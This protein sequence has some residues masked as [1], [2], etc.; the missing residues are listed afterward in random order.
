MFL[1]KNYLFGDSDV[2]LDFT[3]GFLFFEF[4]KLIFFEDCFS[5]FNF[6][7]VFLEGIPN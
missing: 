4:L 5:V 6:G 7:E 1:S 2:L 3:G